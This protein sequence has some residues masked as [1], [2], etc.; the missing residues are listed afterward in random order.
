MRHATKARVAVLG[1]FF[2]FGA[3]LLGQQLT[4][5]VLMSQSCCM[6]GPGCGDPCV[7][8]Q[9]P[10]ASGIGIAV[11]LLATTLLI[12]EMVWKHEKRKMVT[13]VI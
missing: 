3:L 10:T 6:A 2:L 13:R 5:F 11:I 4:G 9:A 8:Q 1:L 7:V 12:G